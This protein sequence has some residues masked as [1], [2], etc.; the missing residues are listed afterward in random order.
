[1]SKCLVVVLIAVGSVCSLFSSCSDKTPQVV[2][3]FP[4]GFRGTARIR[5]KQANGASY[6]QTEHSTTLEFPASGVLDLRDELPTLAWHQISAKYKSGK[7]IPIVE[8]QSK[9]SD[10]DVALRPAGLFE[11]V[12]DWYVVGTYEDLKRTM[13]EK[14]GFKFPPRQSDK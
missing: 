10:L 5:S 4:D 11:N 8:A 3:V 14:R 1:M 9:I 12:E 7:P 6:V 2:F 13:E